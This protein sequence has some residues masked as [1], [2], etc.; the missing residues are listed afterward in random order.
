MDSQKVFICECGSYCHQ[1]IFWYDKEDKQLNLTTHL[2]TYR[3]FF[4]RL[5]V[6][7]RYVFGYK[8]NYGDWDSFLFKPLDE[9]R[10]LAYLN[11]TNLTFKQEMEMNFIPRIAEMIDKEI[12]HLAYLESQPQNEMIDGL[13]QNSN[14][15]LSHLKKRHNEYVEYAKNLQDAS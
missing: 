8:S 13:I 4:K 14:Q 7:I 9:A 2:I 10:L 5:W 1:I 6:A 3:N 15:C 12:R 11:K